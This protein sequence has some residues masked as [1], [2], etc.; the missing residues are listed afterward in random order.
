MLAL[1]TY[2]VQELAMR[3]STVTQTGFTKLIRKYF[4]RGWLRYHLISLIGMNLL[5]LLTEFIGMTAGLVFIGVPLWIAD[6]IAIA[7]VLI[8]IL[9]T[10]YWTKERMALFIA[11][12]NFAFIVLA[13]LTKPDFSA[14]AHTFTSWVVPVGSEGVIWYIIATIGNSIAP[15]MIFFQGNA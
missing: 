3:L 1:F 14:I 10:G 2:T 13:F 11:M 8:I 5:T 6:L 7:L 9:F 15:W 12:V 4:G